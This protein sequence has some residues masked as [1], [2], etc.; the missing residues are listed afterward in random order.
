MATGLMKT[1]TEIRDHLAVLKEEAKARAVRWRYANDAGMVDGFGLTKYDC[2][3]ILTSLGQF[4]GYR[5]YGKADWQHIVLPGQINP[6]VDG[7]EVKIPYLNRRKSCSDYT[8][9]D[10]NGDCVGVFETDGRNNRP[11]VHLPETIP[12]TIRKHRSTNNLF[13]LSAP[14]LLTR[15]ET[16]VP[17]RR[18]WILFQVDN[19]NKKHSAKNPWECDIECWRSLFSQCADLGGAIAIRD[20]ELFSELFVE[21]VIGN[22]SGHV[23]S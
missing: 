15:F 17:A 8:W 23:S 7:R 1:D 6:K 12:V 18:A 3:L 16:Y 11:S 19:R 14:V 20:T 2:G 4:L 22:A 10:G 21:H 9:F 13:K 5:V